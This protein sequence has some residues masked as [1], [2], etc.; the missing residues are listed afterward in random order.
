MVGVDRKGVRRR[1]LQYR[2]ELLPKLRRLAQRLRRLEYNAELQ[3]VLL[4][5]A[6]R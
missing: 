3:I 5:E 1:S 2:V 6:R 4:C